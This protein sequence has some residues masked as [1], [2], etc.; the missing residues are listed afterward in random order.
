MSDLNLQPDGP[1]SLE[2]GVKSSRAFVRAQRSKERIRVAFVIDCIQ[3]WNLGGTERQL[4][5]LV[6]SLDR[7]LFEVLILVLQRSPGALAKDVG[8]P[9][10]VVGQSATSS[11]IRCLLNLWA[12]LTSFQPHVV[13]TFFID[14]TFYGATAAWLNRV[15]VIVQARRNAGHW[16]KTHH[17]LALRILNR[18]VDYW[19]CNSQFVAGT[20]AKREGVPEERISVLSNAI[21]V[22]H[23]SP[24][25]HDGRLA[26]KLKLGL[27]AHAPMI[28]VVSTLRPV[29]GLKTV[30]EAA[31]QLGNNLPDVQIL[32]VGE[33][34]ERD[35]LSKQIATAGLNGIVHLVG[36]QKDVR[37]WLMAADIG[38]LASY[39]ESSS[40]ALLEYM[41]TG[42]P[43]VVSDIP[44][45]HELVDGEFFA[46]GDARGLAERILWL[47]KDKKRSEELAR[48]NRETA[49]KYG[50][51]AF[52]EQVQNYYLRLGLPHC[53]TLPK[54]EFCR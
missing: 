28:V 20:L 29:K 34:P 47:W 4:S 32:M 3:D 13:Q 12:A 52:S 44:A 45:N 2:A 17:T 25:T 21:D 54:D 22:C 26:A 9:V 41:A 48:Q 42:L 15:P 37:P 18:F 51:M 43:T 50:E 53:K 14:G 23:F 16:Q 39:S 24:A 40:N 10:V 1:T 33:G 19:Q 8:C 46:A 5:N 31:S 6:K 38:L 27:E 7:K 11:R 49:T 35:N 30:V 36:G